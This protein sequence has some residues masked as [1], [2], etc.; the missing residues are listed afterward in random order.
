[1]PTPLYQTG[2]IL[3]IMEDLNA[4]NGNG[5]DTQCGVGKFGLGERN[6]NGDRL[7]E[8]CRVNSLVITNTFFDHHK[9]N[10][11]TWTSPGDKM[12]EPDR[13]R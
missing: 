2:D 3:V 6:K 4:K 5:E 8:F 13:L 9:R 12:Q 1:M 10:L 7:A 11:Y